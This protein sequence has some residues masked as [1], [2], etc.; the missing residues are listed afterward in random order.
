MSGRP[1]DRHI[2]C[3]HCEWQPGPDDRWQCSIG[4]CAT[5]W[6]TFWTGGVCPGCG[7]AWRNT[8]CLR[9]GEMSPH[10]DWYHEP[11]LLGVEAEREIERPA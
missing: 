8:Q 5:V 9:C 1:D 10:K 6:N 2:H 11:L 7:Y 4:D 3:P